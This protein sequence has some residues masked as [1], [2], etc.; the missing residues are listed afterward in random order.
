M[1]R[2]GDPPEGTQTVDPAPSAS[3]QRIARVVLTTALALLG[4][5]I[6]HRFLPALAWATILAIA[7]WPLYRRIETVFPPRGH[8][9]ALP[10]VATL[11]VGIVLIIPLAY[12]ALQ[13]AHESGSFFRYI[14]ELRHNGLPV[15]GWLPRVPGLGLP[16]TDWWKANLTDPQTVRELLGRLFSR[17]P[18]D[19]ARLMRRCRTRC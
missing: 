3:A 2:D 5:W 6:L 16:L 11:L 19:S 18:A 4:L 9:I 7:L 13:I 1:D 14:A 10:L 12:A 17:I 15:P 8:R